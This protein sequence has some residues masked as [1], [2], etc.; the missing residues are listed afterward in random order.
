MADPQP[1]FSVQVAKVA[2]GIHDEAAAPARSPA[3]EEDPVRL[4][5][6]PR[7]LEHTPP[8][9]RFHEL[10]AVEPRRRSEFLYVYGAPLLLFFTALLLGIILGSRFL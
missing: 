3:G 6:F 8:R 7:S 9:L 4:V 5:P 1:G 2:S 10:R